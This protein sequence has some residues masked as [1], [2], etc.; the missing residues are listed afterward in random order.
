M[1]AS[2]A[3]ASPPDTELDVAPDGAPVLAG[4]HEADTMVIA[5]GAL[6]REIVHF[7]KMNAVPAFDVAC[8]P[9]WLHN[10]PHLIPD[11]VREKIRE[12]RAAYA[13]ILVA[14]ADCGTGGLLDRVLE[15]EG[16]ERIDGPHCY[17]FYT[18]QAAFDA[19]AEAETGTFYLTDYMVRHFDRL[20]VEGLGLDRHPEL[21]DDYFRHYTRCLYIA[22]TR[23]AALQVKARS[24]AARLGLGYAYR[25]VGYGELEGFLQ[26][27]AVSAS[28]GGT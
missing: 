17:A 5:C 23:D 14:Y 6:A 24:A 12:H 19:L 11:R 10:A 7:R 4:R 15:E 2:P 22:Q 26:R 28:D 16:A 13:R 25:Y 9:A 21:R 20:I 8:I 1:T 27:A 18:G 3:A